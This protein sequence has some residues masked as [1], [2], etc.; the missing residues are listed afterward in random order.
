MSIIYNSAVSGVNTPVAITGI[1]ADRPAA[2]NSFEGTLFVSTD[3]QEIYSL[4][5]GS[6]IL[7]TTGGGGGSQNIDQ[8]LAVGNTA[9]SKVLNFISTNFAAQY[10]Q[11]RTYLN[12]ANGFNTHEAITQVNQ[13]FA[14][15][16]RETILLTQNL[17]SQFVT[18]SD[19]NG[20]NELLLKQF[21]TN[22]VNNFR[23]F[24]VN[25]SYLNGNTITL[26]DSDTVGDQLCRFEVNADVLAPQIQISLVN[27]TNISSNIFEK[28]DITPNRFFFVGLNGNTQEINA[29]I[30]ASG[31]TF[32]S[33]PDYNGTIANV[34]ERIVNN[35][36]DLSLVS[37]DCDKYGIYV[38][39][40]GSLTFN[41][42]F[43]TFALSG[44]DGECVTILAQSTIAI[45]C[46]NSAGAINGNS[47]ILVAGLYKFVLFG[48]DIY[49]SIP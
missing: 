24:E 46:V 40:A 32:V 1:I 34:A 8:V 12:Y 45:N 15:L 22:N 21:E 16:F 44:N 29:N 37:F 42:D 43:Q 4:Q 2:S 41:F 38:V 33:F 17:T 31:S 47:T 11:T 36:V 20:K 19:F 39:V 14:K 48:G 26:T 28:I 9:I 23:S 6:W 49:S 3:T 13:N 5:A 18:E 25:A 10:D 7:V 30:Q 35:A 27:I